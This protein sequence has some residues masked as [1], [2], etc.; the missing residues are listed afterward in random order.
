[1]DQK[2]HV[3]VAS[4]KKSLVIADAVKSNLEEFG[5]FVVVW[6]EG[7]FRTSE[8]F[9]SSLLKEADE[10]DFGIF[11]FADDDK[12]LINDSDIPI[13]TVRDNVLF[14]FGLFTGLIG[15]DRCFIIMPTEH[16]MRIPTDL[17]GIQF[18]TY[19]LIDGPKDISNLTRWISATKTA[20][21]KIAEAIRERGMRNLISQSDNVQLL[22]IG[23]SS[24][25]A[26]VFHC[27]DVA[28]YFKWG[29]YPSG[30]TLSEALKESRPNCDYDLIVVRDDMDF[31]ILWS[32]LAHYKTLFVVDSPPYNKICR[33]IIDNYRNY[34]IGGSVESSYT[35]DNGDVVQYIWV[36]DIAP[37]KLGS[38]KLEVANKSDSF[39]RFYDHF[40]V[41]RLPGMLFPN[42]LVWV[43]Y[44]IHTKGTHAGVC[45]LRKSNLDSVL[46]SLH[47][48]FEGEIPVFFEVV[49]RVPESPDVV[50]NFT[51][52]SMKHHSML[53]SRIDIGMQDS[54]P[55]NLPLYFADNCRIFN[56]ED[57]PIYA[58]H[59][60]PCS[61]CNFRCGKCIDKETRQKK[62]ILS[63]EKITSIFCDLK[64][65]GCEH[66]N[67][68]GGE[69]TL[70]PQLPSILKLADSMGFTS[71]LVT[72]GSQLV[73][74]EVVDAILNFDNL[75]IRVSID[76]NS[77][78][79]HTANHRLPKGTNVFDTIRDS[80]VDILNR[81]K[82]GGYH[83]SLSISYLLYENAFE[84]DELINSCKF[85]KKNGAAAFHLRPVTEEQGKNPE[86]GH[87]REYRNRLELK[88]LIER[89]PGFVVA[90]EWLKQ[91]VIDPKQ[92]PKQ[93][94]CY[95]KCYS[96]FYR[97]AI[98]SY[99]REGKQPQ[100]KVQ[101]KGLDQQVQEVTVTDDAWISL[102]PYNR[103][104][105]GFGC[106]YPSDFREWL[107]EQRIQ[108]A[109]QICPQEDPCRMTVCNRH[110]L[111][112][113]TAETIKR[114]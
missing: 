89:Y 6:D 106:P 23:A 2:P 17:K 26:I 102:C 62:Q 110:E 68:Y 58:V 15:K 35:I 104:K 111:N 25:V 64:K 28:K 88:D 53:Q 101:I 49:Y 74:E 83:T 79:T 51:D 34:V 45:L 7:I 1:M 39:G 92:E 21:A 100:T 56:L 82:K 9:L 95:E 50:E 40:V 69:P 10:S 3:F 73:R 107:T 36:G 66:L 48:M 91:F 63:Y 109:K 77:P 61:A 37:R 54:R 98:S 31:G 113:E 67:F 87:I 70:H 97:F 44:G 11:I 13:P 78:E 22:G 81:I 112:L 41:M 76:G 42:Q 85:W 86:L 5:A 72:N 16:T 33:Y 46:G 18:Q 90:P 93:D 55:P 57:I 71:L 43:I 60:D 84:N 103:Y 114:L 20:C 80:V 12:L 99:I 27:D 105:P 108:L 29:V 38:N 8:F 94:K 14:E 75:H 32:D 47:D 65:A 30:Q 96:A 52:L 24:K 59:F 4:S 19:D